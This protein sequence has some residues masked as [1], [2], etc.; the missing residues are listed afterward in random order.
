MIMKNLLVLT[1]IYPADDLLK[2]STPV[3]HYFTK[4]WVKQGYNV[5]VIHYIVNFPS[6]VY[7]LAKPFTS[8]IEN[9]MSSNIRMYK[10]KYREYEL[11]GVKV[12][13]SP[14]MKFKPHARYSQRQIGQAYKKTLA[15][16][17]K[18]D[19]KPDF[20]VSHFINP[21][22][23]IMH[24]L[25]AFYGVP[26]AYVAHDVGADFLGIYK[27]ECAGYISETDILGYRSLP[28]KKKFEKN[29][30]CGDKPSFMCYSGV[31]KKYI[32]SVG[33]TV[34]DFSNI[35]KFVYVGSF[36]QRKYPAEIVPAVHAAMGKCDFSISYIGS[37]HEKFR[38]VSLA[39]E[40]HCS[41]KVHVLGRIDRSE[42]V[43]ELKRNDVFVMISK[44]ETF[45]LVYLEAMAV[46]C[47]T[48]AS[49]NEGFDGIIEDGVNGFL[50][51]AGN[52]DELSSIIRKIR[53]MS[54]S[55]LS[56]ISTNAIKTAR[57]L[58]DENVAKEYS[59]SLLKIYNKYK[60][61]EEKK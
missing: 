47:I 10:V 22:Y 36:M 53:S 2:E 50:C 7:M 37:G 34:R 59:N 26:T 13:R 46:G 4:E 33:E 19:F 16:L 48:I 35:S 55:E 28:I 40:L 12:C 9:K 25:K 31:P 14:L 39:Q 8:L 24:N 43:N 51:E 5:V 58:T 27:D 61:C 32:S 11:D 42:V 6:I 15:Y 45:G 49:K 57:N 41:E 18:I 3:V 30:Q 29:F 56:K 54:T 44:R 17:K 20:I 23:E 52:V 1:P 60:G 38:I 21:C